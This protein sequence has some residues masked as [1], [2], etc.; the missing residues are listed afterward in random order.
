MADLNIRG[1]SPSTNKIPKV[2]ELEAACSTN[3]T[4]TIIGYIDLFFEKKSLQSIYLLKHIVYYIISLETI[5]KEQFKILDYILDK[6]ME[7]KKQNSSLKRLNSIIVEHALNTSSR[8][9]NETK[10]RLTQQLLKTKSNISMENNN[11][12]PK[13]PNS[14]PRGNNRVNSIV[15]KQLDGKTAETPKEVSSSQSP[16]RSMTSRARNFGSSLIPRMSSWGSKTKVIPSQMN[17][18]NNLNKKNYREIIVKPSVNKRSSSIP[19]VTNLISAANRGISSKKS[20]KFRNEVTGNSNHL[21]NIQNYDYNDDNGKKKPFSELEHLGKL[22]NR[23]IKT[24]RPKKPNNSNKTALNLKTAQQQASNVHNEL[25]T[26]KNYK[27]LFN[28]FQ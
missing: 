24:I 27:K 13:K 14:G 5:T 26:A 2:K 18:S 19:P 25:T 9:G 23:P 1:K 8:K 12:K 20:V 21:E 10:E 22:Q 6:T 15:N 7:L 11:G 28:R 17:N 16:E 4:T 3:N